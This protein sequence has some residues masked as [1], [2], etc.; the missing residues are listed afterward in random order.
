MR[1]RIIINLTSNYFEIK[2]GGLSEMRRTLYLLAS[3]GSKAVKNSTKSTRN[4]RGSKSSSGKSFPVKSNSS[5]SEWKFTPRTFRA[6][7]KEQVV[8]HATNVPSIFTC[9]ENTSVNVMKFDGAAKQL[10]SHKA[11]YVSP[12]QLNYQLPDNSVPEFAFIGRSNVG[13]ST[14][15][16]TL[17]GDPQ[18]V[19]TSKLPG[20][21]KNVNY[22]AFLCP[23]ADVT[24]K[25]S[26]IKD[27]ELYLIDLPG[28]GFA[29]VS[30]DI[31]EKW[32]EM[33]D[34]YVM[35]RSFQILR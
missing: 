35:N 22:F 30:K 29:G 8:V 3:S 5:K 26:N 20:C 34:G 31:R 15:I 28:Y 27:H 25:G 18:L 13:K 23:G 6:N 12:I 1:I 33:I 9:N 32:K 10:F 24:P 11:V 7:P 19:R 2:V 14:L 16:A 21:T 17:L 4:Y